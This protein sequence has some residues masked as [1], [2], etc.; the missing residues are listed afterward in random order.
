MDLRWGFSIGLLSGSALLP[1]V[2]PAFDSFSTRRWIFFY[3]SRSDEYLCNSTQYRLAPINVLPKNG[4][5]EAETF[6]QSSV[7]YDLPPRLWKE[8]FMS[9]RL[10]LVIRK[11][12]HFYALKRGLNH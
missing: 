10:C 5:V 12:M 1:I 2:E 7:G 6:A 3:H 11:S 8:H 9:S 4:T